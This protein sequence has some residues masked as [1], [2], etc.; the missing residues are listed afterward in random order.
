MTDYLDEVEL[1]RVR[2]ERPALV[3][4]TAVGGGDGFVADSTALGILF[5]PPFSMQVFEENAGSSN[6]STVRA[7]W[8]G[9]F[10]VQWPD[11]AATLSAS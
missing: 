4:S 11:A 2:A 10:L 8:N 7:E 6:S 5:L 9:L 3:T 1:L